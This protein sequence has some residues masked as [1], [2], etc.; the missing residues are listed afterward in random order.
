MVNASFKI[1]LLGLS[2]LF[3]SVPSFA[4]GDP[5]ENPALAA[6]PIEV[7]GYSP[8]FSFEDAIQDALAQATT[9]LP[10]RNPDIAVTV[11]VKTIVA[12]SGGNIRP[13][14]LITAVAR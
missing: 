1:A 11:E 10:R 4:S 8:T 2:T 3:L 12:R 7:T 6:G 5:A 13:G 9:R 14:L